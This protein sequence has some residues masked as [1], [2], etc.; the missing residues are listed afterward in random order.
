MII[1]RLIALAAAT[2]ALLAAIGVGAPFAGPAPALRLALVACLVLLAPLFWPGRDDDRAR[3]VSRVIGWSIAVAALAL[4]GMA[5]LAL[6]AAEAAAAAPIARTLALLLPLLVSLHAAS[7][8]L[9]GSLADGAPS[10]ASARETAT[11]IVVCTLVALSALPLWFGPVAEAASGTQPWLVDAVVAASPLAHLAVAGNS[12]LFHTPWM[13]DHA[14]LALL[15]LSYPEFGWLLAGH[16]TTAAL[17][18][19]ALARRRRV[20]ALS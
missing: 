13:Y 19:L 14:N 7:A 2:A 3:A 11:R 9:E 12:D 4:T 17:L 8:L 6:V 16:L 1:P 20:A 10:A 5:G 15:R 18:L